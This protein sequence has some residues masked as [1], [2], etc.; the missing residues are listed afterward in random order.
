M[1][2]ICAFAND[3]QNLGGGYIVIGVAESNG[4]PILLEKNG[5]PPP[6]FHTVNERTYFVTEFLIHPV[7]VQLETAALENEHMPGVTAGILAHVAAHDLS[8]IELKILDFCQHVLHS[9]TEI[10]AHVG[11]Q[12]RTGTITRALANLSSLGLLALTIPEKPKSKNQKRYTTAQGKAAVEKLTLQ[13]R[14]QDGKG[15]PR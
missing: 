12:D 7:F 2:T 8:C 10:L 1:R 4:Q 9:N 3:L 11:A 6:V 14:K 5:S 13:G 15:A